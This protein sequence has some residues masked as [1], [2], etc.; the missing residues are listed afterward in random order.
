[1][2]HLTLLVEILND[3]KKRLETFSINSGFLKDS[4]FKLPPLNF[5]GAKFR[6]YPFLIKVIL[7]RLKKDFYSSLFELEFRPLKSRSTQVDS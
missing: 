4:G 2:K 7:F 3:P 5:K 1:M 6:F